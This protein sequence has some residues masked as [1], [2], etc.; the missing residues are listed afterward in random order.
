MISKLIEDLI[1]VGL[2]E[3]EIGEAIGRDQ[4]SVNRMRND[5]Q[6]PNYETGVKIEKLHRQRCLA[7]DVGQVTAAPRVG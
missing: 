2:S 3:K 6:R 7:P 4:S 5:K 1:D